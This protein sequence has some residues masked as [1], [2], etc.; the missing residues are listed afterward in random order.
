MKKKILYLITKSNWGGAQ[1][2]VYDLA[3]NLPKDEFDVAVAFGGTG[4]KGSQAGG[5][6][7]MLKNAGIRTI[8]LPH[9]T[10]D[11]HLS[12]DV[13]TFFDVIAVLKRER[14]DILH[15]NSSKAGGI[16]ALAGRI[17]GVKNIIFTAHGWPHQEDRLFAA[18]LFILLASW[19]TVLLSHRTIVVSSNDKKVAPAFL[20]ENSI[21]E[22]HNGLGAYAILP[23]EA[24]RAE[25]INHTGRNMPQD[26]PWIGAVAEMTKNNN[27]T[28]LL[29]SFEDVRGAVLVVVGDGEERER[30]EK[31]ALSLNS[32]GRIYFAGFVPDA[33]RLMRAFD[34]YALS[35]L[36]E[37]LP[38]ALLEASSAGLPIAATAVGGVPDIIEDGVTGVLVPNKNRKKLTEAISKLVADEE[39]RDTYGRNARIRAAKNFSVETMLEKTLAL[40]RA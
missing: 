24:A 22:I 17:M 7:A 40:Y 18:K 25:L 15:I 28:L 39:L 37:G 36:K 27:L 32:R 5:L 34:V 29:K 1:R 12:A 14:P 30:L 11:I 16:G 38:Y 35:S 20:K 9:S 8:F 26:V 23:K 21:T 6:D 4:E 2:Y 31:V 3:T 33:R 19:T 10:R 13:R